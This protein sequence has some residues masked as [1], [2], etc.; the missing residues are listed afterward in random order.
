M[1]YFTVR[2]ISRRQSCLDQKPFWGG[3]VGGGRGGTGGAVTSTVQ[4]RL[5]KIDGMHN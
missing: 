1:P 5:I 4:D 2:A 3:G